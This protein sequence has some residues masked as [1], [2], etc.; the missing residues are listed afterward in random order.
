MDRAQIRRRNIVTKGE[1]PYRT[2]M[3]LVFDSG[4]FADYLE[5]ALVMADYAGFA[6]RKRSAV[7]PRGIGIANYVESPVGAPR[8]RIELHVERDALIAVSGTQSA[9]QGHETSFAQVLADCLELPIEKI[10]LR[11]GDTAV[12]KSGGG[13]HSDRSLFSRKCWRRRAARRRRASRRRRPG[14]Q[15]SST[16]CRTSRSK[17]G[18]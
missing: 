5:R 8:E 6:A 3:R 9:G 11:T 16:T 7:R 10:R 15:C 18:K 17:I 13:T 4:D 1:L 14:R 2:P 12:V